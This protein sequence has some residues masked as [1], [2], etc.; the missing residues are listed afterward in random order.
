MSSK[1]VL[2][3]AA[4]PDDEVLGCGGT[5]AKH[6]SLGHEVHVLIIAEGI[7]SRDN[8]RNRDEHKNELQRLAESAK[9]ANDILEVKT[10]S[11]LDFPDNRL[12]SVDRIEVIKAIEKHAD[13]IKPQI[14][15][16]H[17]DTDLNIDH[18]IINECVLT[19]FRPV[20]ESQIE[21]IYFFEVA[22]STGWYSSVEKSSFV[23]NWHEDISDTLDLKIKALKQY[24]SEMKEWPHAR[25]IEAVEYQARWR[26]SLVGLQAAESFYL[27]RKVSK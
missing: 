12:D 19:A 15:Y 7:T 3:V 8:I 11:L 10:L 25:S 14:V 21:N 18:R 4:H 17:S 24:D 9:K 20:P 2:V 13:N 1:T 16:T 5:I 23:S 6:K 22:S 26:G 27:A